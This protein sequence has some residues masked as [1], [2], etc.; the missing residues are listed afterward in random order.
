MSDVTARVSQAA[1]E[2]VSSIAGVATAP[3]ARRAPAGAG[4]APV[5]WARANLF[6]SWLSSAVTILLA[7]L[8]VR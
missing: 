1:G 6:N 4:F 7:Y 5:A 3:I 2:P 8:I